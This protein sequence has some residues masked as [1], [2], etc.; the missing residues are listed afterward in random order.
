MNHDLFDGL[1]IDG[2][3][4]RS[5]DGTLK[6]AKDG[7]TKLYAFSGDLQVIEE[8]TNNDG[9]VVKEILDGNVGI[10]IGGQTYTR[11]YQVNGTLTWKNNN[12]AIDLALQGKF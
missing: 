8:E 5:L 3:G 4:D 2:V 7:K 1:S 11:D 12:N 6:V 9:E 10:T